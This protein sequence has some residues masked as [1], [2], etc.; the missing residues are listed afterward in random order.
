MQFEGLGNKATVS[1][2]D[3]DSMAVLFLDNGT[4]T[5]CRF[6]HVA[7]L[8]LLIERAREFCGLYDVQE[9]STLLG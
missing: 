2:D 3:D 4:K 9:H 5:V 8:P 1:C 7:M 6:G